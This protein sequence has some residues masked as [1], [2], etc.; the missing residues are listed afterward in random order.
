MAN[1]KTSNEFESKL[2]QVM[3]KETLAD[4]AQY[5]RPNFFDEVPVYSRLSE[6]GF[7][8]RLGADRADSILLA[9]AL[10][11]LKA[12]VWYESPRWPFFA[13][14]T[15]W[16]NPEDHFIVPNIFVCNG[17]VEERLAG[18]LVLEEVKSPASKRIKRLFS[19]LRMPDPL[20]VLED[21]I[22]TPDLSRVFIGYMIPPYPK[23]VTVHA[24]AQRVTARNRQQA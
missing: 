13:A 24:F 17:K 2:W 15:I 20:Q 14:V 3:E 7:L 22:T 8:K 19:R 11:F 1:M 5:H 10:K 18:R 6:V 23:M 16:N 4:L 12:I 21:R 9:F